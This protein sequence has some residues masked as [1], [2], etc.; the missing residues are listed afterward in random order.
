MGLLAEASKN[1]RDFSWCL[2]LELEDFRDLASFTE[3]RD[4]W[5][6]DVFWDTLMYLDLEFHYFDFSVSRYLKDPRG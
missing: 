4:A 1:L 2:A 3:I 5:A 6:Y